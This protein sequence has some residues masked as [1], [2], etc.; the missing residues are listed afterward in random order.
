MLFRVD[1]ETSG[2][3]DNYAAIYGAENDFTFQEVA[4]STTLVTMDVTMEQEDEEV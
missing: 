1:G 3:A 2:S 4:P